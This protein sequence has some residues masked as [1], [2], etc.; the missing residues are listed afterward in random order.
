MLHSYLLSLLHMFYL[1]SITSS[2]NSCSIHMSNILLYY[3]PLNLTEWSLKA[4][5]GS[6]EDEC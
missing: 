6:G 4:C 2:I 1:F 3:H 5:G